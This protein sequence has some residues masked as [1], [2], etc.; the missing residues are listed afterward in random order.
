MK[1]LNM[2]ELK[3]MSTPMSS[4]M[5]LGSDKDGESV[6]QREYRSMIGSHRLHPVPHN[7]MAGHSVHRGAVCALSDF[8]TLFTSNGNS[9]N[10]Q[11]S[12]THSWVWDMVFCF[13]FA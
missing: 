5:S 10:F 1:K 7:D 4:T 11:V 2:A 8:P 3:P 6:D 12:Q 9:A 13:F